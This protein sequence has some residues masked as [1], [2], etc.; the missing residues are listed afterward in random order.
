MRR[1]APKKDYK[2][3]VE[4]H[5]HVLD[6]YRMIEPWIIEKTLRHVLQDAAGCTFAAGA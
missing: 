6:A 2:L 1:N 5:L 4:L 3:V